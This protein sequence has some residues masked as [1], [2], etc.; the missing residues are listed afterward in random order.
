MKITLAF[1]L[2]ALAL[3]GCADKLLSDDRIKSSTAMTLGVPVTSISNRQ[4]DGGV[5]TGYTVH[6][7]RGT[8]HC[9]INGG[10]VMAFGMTNPPS[11]GRL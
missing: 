8:Y 4:Y 2:A 11:C 1:A 3:S 10:T 9:V 7:S 5:N 6:T